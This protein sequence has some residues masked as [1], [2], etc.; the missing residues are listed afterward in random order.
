M[1][2]QR[3]RALTFLI[4]GHSMRSD[5]AGGQLP[6]TVDN[7]NLYSHKDTIHKESVWFC[8][9]LAVKRQ[10]KL[11]TVRNKNAVFFRGFQILNNSSLSAQRK[12]SKHRLG[13]K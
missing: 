6:K 8:S 5:T 1:I 3:H 9:N 13:D 12:P 2:C 7:F 10:T 11:K 4:A